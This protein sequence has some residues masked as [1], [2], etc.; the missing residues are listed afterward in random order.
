MSYLEAVKPYLSDLTLDEPRKLI[1][2]IC[3]CGA[4]LGFWGIRG[5]SGQNVRR[6]LTKRSRSESYQEFDIPKRSGGSRHISAPIE[7]LKQIQQSLNLMLQT[8]CE[9]SDSATGFVPGRSVVTNASAHLGSSILFN[10]DLQDF[11]PSIS[12]VAVRRALTEELGALSPSREVINIISSLATVPLPDGK[13]VLPQGAPTSPVI[14]NL[15]LKNLDKRLTRFAEKNGYRYTRY[16][17]DITFSKTGSFNPECPIKTDAILSI[18]KDSGFTVNPKKTILSTASE[19]KEV[20]GLT[21]YKKINVRRRYVKQLRVL[22]HLWESRGFAEAQKIY[23]RDFRDGYE[24]NLACVVNGKINYLRMIKGSHDST[25]RRFKAR[26][27]VLMQQ[28]KK[29]SK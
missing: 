8:L 16:A 14:S 20:T 12:K 6:F 1:S 2:A 3:S 23:T 26:F 17:D 7:P 28:L 24:T 19:R 13:E 25:Y 18:I 5:L 11:F 21:V 27:R 15:V 29:Q 22:L 10:C 9:V 4:A